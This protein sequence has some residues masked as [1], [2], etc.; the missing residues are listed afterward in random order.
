MSN[1]KAVAVVAAQAVASQHIEGLFA[2]FRAEGR[3]LIGTT[4]QDEEV[5][6]T[7]MVNGGEGLE[8]EELATSLA[9]KLN[10]DETMASLFGLAIQFEFNVDGFKEKTIPQAKAA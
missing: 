2:S 4:V 7:A 1:K 10:D 5:K 9:E 8:S 3:H 6:V